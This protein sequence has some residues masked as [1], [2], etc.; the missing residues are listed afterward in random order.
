MTCFLSAQTETQKVQVVQVEEFQE[1]AASEQCQRTSNLIII[2]AY[3]QPALGP[4]EADRP[5]GRPEAADAP[6]GQ[7][8]AGEAQLDEAAGRVRGGDGQAEGQPPHY[9]AQGRYFKGSGRWNTL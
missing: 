5:E 3:R 4:A 7:V 6:G 1:R 2:S 8:L 9:S